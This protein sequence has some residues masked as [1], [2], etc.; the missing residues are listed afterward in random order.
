MLDENRMMEELVESR[1][2]SGWKTKADFVRWAIHEGL[3]QIR[4]E[5][6]FLSREMGRVEALVE[7]INHE[8]RRAQF[9]KMLDKI[10]RSVQSWRD[11]GALDEARR[12]ISNISER[13]RTEFS[14]DEDEWIRLEVAKRLKKYEGLFIQINEKD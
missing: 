5:V 14:N 1:V 7:F 13:V 8:E 11:L 4:Q 3:K 10:D 9:V 2:I 12:L 6:P